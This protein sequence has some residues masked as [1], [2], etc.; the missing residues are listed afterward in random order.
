MKQMAKMLIGVVLALLGL[1]WFL[2]GA[3]ILNI[4]PILCFAN[5]EPITGGSIVWA[6]VGFLFFIM[7]TMLLRGYFKNSS[8]KKS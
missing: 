5:C 4:A 1:L 2:Q 7:G 3:G 6:I 8:E